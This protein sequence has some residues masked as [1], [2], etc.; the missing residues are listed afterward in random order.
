M[1]PNLGFGMGMGSGGASSA[2]NAGKFGRKEGHGMGAAGRRREKQTR[3]DEEVKGESALW[4]FVI[5]T[6]VLLIIMGLGGGFTVHAD[7]GGVEEDE[8]D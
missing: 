1:D 4:R 3:M 8:V 6:G 2:D 5:I 7:T